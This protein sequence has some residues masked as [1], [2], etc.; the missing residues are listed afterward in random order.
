[1][2]YPYSRLRRLRQSEALRKLVRETNIN[3]SKL[4]Y[5]LFVHEAAN[6]KEPIESIPGSYRH[7]IR[8][9]LEEVENCMKLGIDAFLLFGISSIKD[10]LASQSFDDHGI[11]QRSVREIKRYFKDVVLITDVCLCEYTSNGHCGIVKDGVIINDDTVRLLAKVALSHANAG[12]DVVAPSDMMDGRVKVI[13][14][15]LD[16][17]GHEMIPIMS[18]SAKYASGFYGPFREA[19]GSAPQFG[20]RKSYQMDYSNAL[21][22][23]R[24]VELDIEEG[25]DIVMVKP[26][27]AYLD[28]IKLVKDTF[29]FPTAAFNVSGE[30][31]MVKMASKQGIFNERMITEEIISSIFRAGADIVITYHAKD[32]AMWNHDKVR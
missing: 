28:V 12:A 25:A 23:L 13:R 8:S 4:V 24:E 21:E 30:Y 29:R 6:Q 16:A 17:S 5:P 20:D 10:E 26:A 7:T 9:L 3:I 31:S 22:A 19:V 2:G 18:Y 15:M 27:L 32:L 1:M 14:E 11:V